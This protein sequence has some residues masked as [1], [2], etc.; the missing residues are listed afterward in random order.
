MQKF[1]KHQFLD[2]TP[3]ELYGL[4]PTGRIGAFETDNIY[5][6]EA[7]SSSRAGHTKHLSQGDSAGFRQL[8]GNIQ[9]ETQ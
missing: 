8:Q 1:D 9:Q 6:R 7:V 5:R 3:R 4:G 2:D